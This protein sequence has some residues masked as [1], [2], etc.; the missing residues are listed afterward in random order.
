MNLAF[1]AKLRDLSS[2]S[3]AS[4]SLTK[5]T[6]VCSQSAATRFNGAPAPPAYQLVQVRLLQALYVEFQKEC[7]LLI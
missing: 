3:S 1:A 2:R 4:G 5:R 7:Q 6:I